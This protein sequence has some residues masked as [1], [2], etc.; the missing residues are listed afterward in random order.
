MWRLRSSHSAGAYV[1]GWRVDQ[2]LRTWPFFL[3]HDGSHPRCA[4]ASRRCL[5][6]GSMGARAWARMVEMKYWNPA[7]TSSRQSAILFG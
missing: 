6:I 5:F 2:A 4:N 3:A 7:A 1:G